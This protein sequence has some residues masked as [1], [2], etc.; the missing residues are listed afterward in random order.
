MTFTLNPGQARAMQETLTTGARFCLLYGGSRSGKTALLSSCLWDRA[1]YAPGSR[2]L[3]L[4]KEA[5]NAKGSLA[6][7]TLP[8]VW[9]LKFPDAPVPDFNGEYGYFKLP[10]DSELWI[11]GL[12]DTKAMERILGRE[13]ATI[14][15]NEASEIPYEAHPLMETRLA[16]VC[17]TLDGDTLTQRMYYD[18]NPTTR[19]HWTYR[20]FVEGINPGDSTQV[21]DRSRYAYSRINPVDNAENLTAD[22]LEGLRTQEARV[23]RRFYEGEYSADAEE[24][25][26]RRHYIKRSRLKEDGSWPVDMARIVVAVDPAVTNN[27]GSDETGIIAVGAGVDGY[28]YVLAD[29]SGRYRPEE[30]ARRAVSLYKSLDAD[31]IVAEVN[32]GGDLVEAT[33]R[34]VEGHVPYRAVRAS[35]GSVTRA[36][37]TA[38][39]YERGKVFHI[40][41]FPDLEDQMCAVTVGFDKKAAGWSP[42]RVDALVW[43]MTDLFPTISARTE[44]RRDLPRPQ[45][46]MV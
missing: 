17:K 34:A 40:G 11:G 3:A 39:L 30:W 42:D 45:F 37:P 12:N 16:Q 43:A 6:L 46:S 29:E 21:V 23:R 35:R 26:W 24:G 25:L 27:P 8:K 15:G 1:L 5:I 18:L 13:Y 38:G 7:D 9:K 10:N 28:G 4:R 2:H 31:R 36:E 41:E 14:Y 32:M 44:T 20:L 33:I 22:Y 19:M